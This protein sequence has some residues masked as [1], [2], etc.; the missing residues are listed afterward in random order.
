MLI[1][2]NSLCLNLSV[3]LLLHTDRD[4]A[5]YLTPTAIRHSSYDTRNTWQHCAKHLQGASLHSAYQTLGLST[6]N[7]E[8]DKKLTE[9]LNVRYRPGQQRTTHIDSSVSRLKLAVSMGS[10]VTIFSKR[11]RWKHGV[12]M[13]TIAGRHS[14]VDSWQAQGREN[15]AGVVLNLDRLRYLERCLPTIQFSVRQHEFTKNKLTGPRGARFPWTTMDEVKDRGTYL[16]SQQPTAHLVSHTAP[17]APALRLH[18][19]L[20]HHTIPL[21]FIDFQRDSDEEHDCSSTSRDRPDNACKEQ[22]QTCEA[23]LQDQ[24]PDKEHD[25]KTLTG[26]AVRLDVVITSARMGVNQQKDIPARKTHTE[27]AR[28]EQGGLQIGECELDFCDRQQSRLVVVP[29]QR[30]EWG[31]RCP[32]LEERRG[33]RSGEAKAG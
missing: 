19:S 27:K 32:R 25:D 3:S 1:D 12:T 13:I 31:A 20:L 17:T 10:F 9:I 24:H 11:P 30:E 16:Q 18:S 8:S 5:R 28:H 15:P 4:K 7:H 2:I 14:E 29:V 22:H 21:A 6:T 26:E 23:Q 33:E